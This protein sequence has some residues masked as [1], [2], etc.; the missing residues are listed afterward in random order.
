MQRIAEEQKTEIIEYESLFL[1]HRLCSDPDDIIRK[2]ALDLIAEK[3][4]LSKVHTKHSQVLSDYDRLKELVSSALNVWKDGVIDLRIKQI[5]SELSNNPGIEEA[6]RLLLEQARL[7]MLRSQ[8][9]TDRVII[10]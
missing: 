10:P 4:T 5:Q 6:E 8:L 1:Q 7:R 2:E 3:E 9:I